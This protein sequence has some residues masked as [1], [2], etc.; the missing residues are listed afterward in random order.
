MISIPSYFSYLQDLLPSQFRD[1]A[2]WQKL[3]TVIGD[4]LDDREADVQ[5]LLAARTSIDDADGILLDQ[6][7]LLFGLSRGGKPD[8]SY[9]TRILAWM[10]CLTSNGTPEE[11]ISIA[12][13]LVDGE[14]VVYWETPPCTFNLELPGPIHSVDAVASSEVDRFI[15]KAKPMGV[16]IGQLI[17]RVEDAARFDVTLGGFDLGK[18]ATQMKGIS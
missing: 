12:R 7:G 5:T 3:L 18:F 1:G 13:E 8:S 11:L 4:A 6:W 14:A 17:D 2:N 16:S 9:R 15:K 10:Q